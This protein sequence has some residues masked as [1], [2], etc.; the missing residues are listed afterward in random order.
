MGIMNQYKDRQIDIPNRKVCETTVLCGFTGNKM[1][2]FF[3]LD[4]NLTAILANSLLVLVL[5]QVV[6]M[7]AVKG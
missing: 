5:V 6:M 7:D 1:C 4:C 3:H 2:C